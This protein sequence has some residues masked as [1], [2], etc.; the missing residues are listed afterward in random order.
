MRKVNKI[1]IKQIIVFYS[2]AWKNRNDVM[3]NSGRYREHVID[4]DKR[5]IE[6]IEKGN[7]PSIRKY[8][9]MQQLELDKSNTGYIRLQNMS[10]TKMM[11]N[12][13]DEI[14][15]DIR[16]YFPVR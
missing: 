11:K 5:L 15:N 1:I 7:K 10:T 2:K 9:R 13:K 12:A 14:V 4:Q 16:N 6:E 3:H 8:V